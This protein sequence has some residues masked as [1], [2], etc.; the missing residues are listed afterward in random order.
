[1]VSDKLRQTVDKAEAAVQ[2]IDRGYGPAVTWQQACE[3]H[4]HLW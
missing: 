3:A 2:L 1:M 4:N